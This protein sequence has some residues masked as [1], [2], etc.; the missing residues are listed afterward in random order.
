MEIKKDGWKSKRTVFPAFLGRAMPNG[1]S[2]RASPYLPP[3]C[4]GCVTLTIC[5]M[6]DEQLEELLNSILKKREDKNV[7]C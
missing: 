4:A 6:E 1:N 7:N 5:V 3:E 2:A